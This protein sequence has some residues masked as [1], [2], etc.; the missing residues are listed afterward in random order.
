MP[1]SIVLEFHSVNGDIKNNISKQF[2]GFLF[3]R[4]KEFNSSLSCKIHD[5]EIKPFSISQIMKDKSSSGLWIKMSFL[6]DELILNIMPSFE[7]CVGN[8]YSI[9]IYNIVIDKIVYFSDKND[10][11]CANEYLDIIN[12]PIS[13]KLKFEFLTPTTFKQGNHLLP[14]PIPKLM[15]KN[16]LRKWNEFSPYTISDLDSEDIENAVIVSSY[17]IK[18]EKIEFGDFSSIGFVGNVT[19]NILK[20][21]DENL[22][23]SINVLSNFTIYS[24][25]GY[26]NTMGMGI[27]RRLKL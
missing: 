7:S 13:Y 2:H 27:C 16:I 8:Q 11:V 3:N 25:V 22:V 20:S 9:G 14:L 19:F 24:G 18:T 1:M 12:M 5:S 4:L 21:A 26:K 23:K 17:N 15:F 10:W 6:T